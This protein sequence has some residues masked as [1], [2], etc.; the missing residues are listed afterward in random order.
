M[1]RG[2][3]GPRNGRFALVGHIRPA[4]LRARGALS[5][6]EAQPVVDEA[7]RQLARD[8]AI[9]RDVQG[10]LG[11]RLEVEASGRIASLGV[12]SD[13]LITPESGYGASSQVTGARERTMAAIGA[14]R[15]PERS[16][17]STLT[18]AVALP[19]P[20]LRPIE[21]AVARRTSAPEAFRR[22]LAARAL[23][24]RGRV[25]ADRLILDEPL[26][27]EI[28]IAGETI[29]ASFVAPMWVPSQRAQLEQAL[30]ALLESA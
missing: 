24:L 17:G 25:E 10:T 20:E 13:T 1:I 7:L 16:G 28:R 23:G 19:V 14:V 11:L 3:D 21:I 4:S 26:T 18:L 29:A 9:A 15:F 30:T 27:G 2:A 6:K 8:A 22:I 5:A 12:L